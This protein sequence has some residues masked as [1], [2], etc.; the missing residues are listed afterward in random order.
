MKTLI[1]YAAIILGC[2][3]LFD[4]YTAAGSESSTWRIVGFDVN[5]STYMIYKFV[6]GIFLIV[7]G[8]AG[9]KAGKKKAA[10]STDASQ[11]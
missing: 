9:I 3:A 8:I 5:H 6:T 2:I 4:L 11:K 1:T 7:Y 10:T